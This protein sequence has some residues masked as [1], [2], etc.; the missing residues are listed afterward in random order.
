MPRAN[1]SKMLATKPLKKS[2][3]DI[4]AKIAALSEASTTLAQKLYAEQAAEAQA[5]GD[6][7]QADA[8]ADGAGDTV[9]AEFEEVKDDEDKK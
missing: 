4:E 9:D 6:D 7:G 8:G 3:D 1:R 5:A 2:K